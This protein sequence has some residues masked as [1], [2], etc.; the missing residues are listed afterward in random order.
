MKILSSSAEDKQGQQR[1]TGKGRRII[2]GVY[3]IGAVTL[4]MPLVCGRFGHVGLPFRRL[5]Y[6]RR[7]PA[8]EHRRPHRR[9]AFVSP[10]FFP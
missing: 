4:F 2:W 1:A 6:D 9:L 7:A 8:V 5:D 10:K 3:L